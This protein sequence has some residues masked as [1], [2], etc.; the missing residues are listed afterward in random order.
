MKTQTIIGLTGLAGTG[1][2]TVANLLCA[3]LE[4]ARYAFAEPLRHEIVNA[5]GIDARLLTDRHT[6]EVPTPELALSRCVDQAFIGTMYQ[7]LAN[8]DA[9]AFFEQQDAPRSPRQ[10]MQWWG[11]EYRREK[12]GR[13]YWT[14]RLTGRVLMQQHNGQRLHVITDV[15]FPEEA[16]AIRSMGGQIWQV[17]R[18]HSTHQPAATH[19]SE[20]DGSAYRPEVV[21]NNTH[22]I[23]HLQHLVLGAYFMETAKIDAADLLSI[24]TAHI[25]QANSQWLAQREKPAKPLFI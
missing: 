21:I 4:F 16:A 22:D 19:S 18:P 20:V 10:V 3:H 24:G 6:K 9:K 23:K 5:F 11:T 8:N 13:Q 17:K 7:H 12:F 15:R 25:P 2:D 14:Q 1:K